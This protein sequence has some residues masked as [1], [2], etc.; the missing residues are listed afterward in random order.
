MMRRALVVAASLAAFAI[1]D[2]AAAQ[3]PMT[4]PL[5]SAHGLRTV[6]VGTDAAKLRG[7]V[8]LYREGGSGTAHGRADASCQEKP[9]AAGTGRLESWFNFA[10]A[11]GGRQQIWQRTGT[12][13]CTMIDVL[14]QGQ[15]ELRVAFRG[16]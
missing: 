13:T 8:W 7:R 5:A 9:T 4:L 12:E 10:I 3:P 11:P 1:A 14:L 6:E 15:G 2:D 16:Y